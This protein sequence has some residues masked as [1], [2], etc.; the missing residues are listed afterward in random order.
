[1]TILSKKDNQGIT[2]LRRRMLDP[3]KSMVVEPDSTE[4]PQMTQ[5]VLLAQPTAQQH[6]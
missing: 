6:S 5:H 1:V 3:K 4:Q 2:R